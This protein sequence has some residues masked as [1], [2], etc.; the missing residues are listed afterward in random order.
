MTIDSAKDKVAGHIEYRTDLFKAQ[1]VQSLVKHFE[2]ILESIIDFPDS[3]IWDLKYLPGN[4]TKYLE[5]VRGVPPYVLPLS[6]NYKTA[7]P[8]ILSSR[9]HQLPIGV[10]GKFQCLSL[11]WPFYNFIPCCKFFDLPV[12]KS[13]ALLDKFSSCS[14]LLGT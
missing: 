8:R 3:S 14:G 6:A 2:V 1:T 7:Q 9:G 5:S 10:P 13:Q 11:L 12:Q 4:E